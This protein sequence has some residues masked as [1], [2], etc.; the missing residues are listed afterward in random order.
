MGLSFRS[1]LLDEQ[2][3]ELCVK[4]RRPDAYDVFGLSYVYDVDKNDL[5][6][7]YIE[8]SKL[9]HPDHNN[10]ATEAEK[11]RITQVSA[12]INQAYKDLGDPLFRVEFLL[13]IL[14]QKHNFQTDTKKLPSMFLMEML[15]LQEELEDLDEDP[16]ECRLEEIEDSANRSKLTVLTDV[17]K[18]LDD[19][20]SSDSDNEQF[21]QDLRTQIN[22]VRYYIRILDTVEKIMEKI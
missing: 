16:K 1:C 11:N 5:E 4:S 21:L 6:S 12:W 10:T 17:G 13:G 9:T 3:G 19:Y 18:K 8:I 14:E 15:E 2:T 20:Y 7:R 22:T